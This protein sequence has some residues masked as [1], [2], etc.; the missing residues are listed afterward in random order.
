[1]I[2]L[3]FAAEK[4]PQALQALGLL[5]PALGCCYA[6]FTRQGGLKYFIPS[7]Y[8][9]K[10][11]INLPSFLEKK[12]MAHDHEVNGIK[13]KKD[14]YVVSIPTNGDNVDNVLANRNDLII[15]DALKEGEIIELVSLK[16]DH[17]HPGGSAGPWEF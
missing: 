15:T 14:Q 3:N 4:I 10:T 13:P 5:V 1:M 7:D 17:N 16:H 6:Q 8:F 12:F 2:E 9:K 11:G